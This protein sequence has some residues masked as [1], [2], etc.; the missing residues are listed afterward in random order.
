MQASLAQA[1]SS[2]PSPKSLL[3]LFL[4]KLLATHSPKEPL[5]PS[6]GHWAPSLQESQ[7]MC[8]YTKLEV[9]NR[10]KGPKAAIP[11]VVGPTMRL[12]R[13]GHAP[14][15]PMSF[16][17]PLALFLSLSLSC[18]L[19]LSLCLSLSLSVYETCLL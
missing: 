5:K 15:T 19:S 1:T 14:L 7:V 3:L 10:F 13:L 9:F 18:S 2:L 4:I 8:T 11:R 6:I 17:F 16:H 12:L